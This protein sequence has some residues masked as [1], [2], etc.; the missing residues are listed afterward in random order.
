MQTSTCPWVE[1]PPCSLT[2]PSVQ[3]P[4]THTTPASAPWVQLWL[5]SGLAGQSISLVSAPVHSRLS[6]HIRP[7]PS[8]TK[9]NVRARASTVN[10]YYIYT[11][12]NW[13]TYEKI[14]RDVIAIFT[15]V[16]RS[17]SC[18]QVTRASLVSHKS[19][20]T[21]PQTLLWQTSTRPSETVP[22]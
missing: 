5:P 19:P 15:P 11:T 4:V 16:T 8:G 12:M 21:V 18:L 10:Q 2:S 17:S 9:P 1:V 7:E 13:N 20:Q 6:S 22:P 3:F 14:S